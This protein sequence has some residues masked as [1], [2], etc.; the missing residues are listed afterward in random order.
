MDWIVFGNRILHPLTGAS[1]KR[2]GST[3]KYEKIVMAEEVYASE[4]KA[5]E[6]LN[7]ITAQLVAATSKKLRESGDE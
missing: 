5:A 4:T 2:D 6:E 1:F 3:L 7:R